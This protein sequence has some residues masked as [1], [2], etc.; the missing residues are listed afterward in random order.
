MN[1]EPHVE[2]HN[3]KKMK[4]SKYGQAGKM[5]VIGAF[6]TS[7][8]KLG[9]FESMEE[10]QKAMLGEYKLPDDTSIENAAKTIV[11]DDFISF[12]CIEHCFIK[13]SATY[14]P[15]DVL[16]VNTNYGKS[17]LVSNS[18]NEDIA[19]ACILLAEEEFDI[20]TVAENV[21][22]ATSQTV[23]EVTST[24]LNPVWKTL[25]DFNDLQ[26]LNQKPFGIITGIDFTGADDTILGLFKTLF[27]DQGIFKAVSTPVR[28]IGEENSLN[29][30][31]SGCWHAAF[32]AGR[33]VNLSETAKVYEDILGENTKDLYPTTNTTAGA[34][35]WKKLLDNGF[36]TT[37]Y[38]NRREH[39]IQCLSNI[40]PADYDMKIER[41]RNYVLKRLVVADTLGDDN[42]EYAI[43]HVDGVF[44]YEKETAIENRLIKDMEYEFE[45]VDSETV[46]ARVQMAIN[47]IIR[48]FIIE[49]TLEIATFEEE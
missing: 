9:V 6:P 29:I 7:T 31:Q 24:I 22:L 18:T 28:Y 30:A 32:T 19:N 49:N 37:K 35:T 27:K 5:A 8:F 36:H 25:K 11:P 12:Y 20:L 15:E 13:N 43:E 2:M 17:T 23:E 10:A 14:G 47:D 38:K 39:T 48:V 33:A 3:V 44:K 4:T 41:T 46:K 16:F 42:D 40:T 45:K 1:I 34:I 26:F 21:K